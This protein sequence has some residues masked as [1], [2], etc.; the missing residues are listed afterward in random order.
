MTII[1]PV[2]IRSVDQLELMRRSGEITAKALKKTIKSAKV[3][4]SLKELD[5]I[6]E[7]EIFRL[8]GKPSF[9]TVPNYHW[10]TCLTIN[11]EVVHGIPREIKLNKGDILS[12]DLGAIF[13][14]WHTDAAW[15][16]VVDGEDGL[17]KRYF[18][19]IGEQ[20]LWLATN[21]AI[22]GKNVGDIS[23]VIQTRIEGAGFNVVRTF[24]GHGVGRRAHEEPEIP[25]IG[26][27]GIGLP[28]KRGM[29]LAIEVIYTAGG[30]DV[31]QKEDGW[32]I[33]T[34]D[35]SLAGLFEMS[36]IVGKNQSEVI[37]DWR[38]VS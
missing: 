9:K 31:C 3:G 20:A 8:G 1:S 33:V 22:E 32:T 24:V 23:E 37:T 10:T 18:L 4:V 25:G 36:V 28:L 15:S 35:G 26:K 34:Q 12:I 11:D 6:A 16:V 14:G 7:D 5:K 19:E 29:T 30:F 17:Q 2:P 21:Q 13:K 38:K 27:K